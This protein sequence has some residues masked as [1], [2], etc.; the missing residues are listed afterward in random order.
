MSTPNVP[1]GDDLFESAEGAAGSGGDELTKKGTA[2]TDTQSRRTKGDDE[3][4]E[5]TKKGTAGTDTQ[6]RRTKGVDED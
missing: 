4:D 2:G 6:S 1:S 5:L 3:P